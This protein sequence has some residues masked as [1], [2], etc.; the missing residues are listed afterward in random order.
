MVKIRLILL[1]I[2][3]F[4]QSARLF[5]ADIPVNPPAILLKVA[6]GGNKG[7]G[8]LGIRFPVFATIPLGV[9]FLTS[10]N[11][12]F[13]LEYSPLLGN[14]VVEDSLFGGMLGPEGILVDNGG[15][16]G[17][18]RLYMRGFTAQASI[19]KVFLLK[20]GNP[21]FG[22]D[23]QLGLGMM[24]HK[25][26]AKFDSE[27]LPQLEGAYAEGYDKL[28][29]GFMYSLHAGLHYVNP[30]TISLFA[31]IDLGQGF[32]RNQR[33]W[34]YGIMRSDNR[35]RNDLYVGFSAG[36]FIPIVLKPAKNPDYFD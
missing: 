26:T 18:V 27:S 11:L 8:D 17:I 1:F 32:T 22:M 2:V 24:Q 34:D 20:P 10:H 36:M 14:Q 3:C 7:M 33:N 16:P 23:V 13:G 30:A 25:I 21:H 28:T 6:G 12:K 29:N 4:G 15:F 35:M 5:S 19:G 9:Q 31:G